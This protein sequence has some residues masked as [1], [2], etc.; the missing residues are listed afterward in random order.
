MRFPAY[1]RGF[2]GHAGNGVASFGYGVAWLTSGAYSVYMSTRS[3]TQRVAEKVAEAIEAANETP[4]G[5]AKVTGIHRSTLL[6]RLTGNS[7]F[8][9]IELELLADH[10]G[11]EP[12]DFLR[13]EVAA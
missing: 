2:L 12:A 9:T 5:V 11:T 13:S 10:F 7:P 3:L 4:T 8:T 1:L 6:R